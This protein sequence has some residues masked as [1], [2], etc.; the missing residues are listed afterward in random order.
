M[1]FLLTLFSLAASPPA[2]AGHACDLDILSMMRPAE[3]VDALAECVKDLRDENRELRAE[4][5]SVRDECLDAYRTPN[6]RAPRPA[7][8]EAHPPAK[9]HSQSGG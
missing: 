5:E 9:S 2:H 8:R 6:K 7:R 3:K 1:I 4:I